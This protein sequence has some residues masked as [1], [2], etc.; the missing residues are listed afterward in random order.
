MADRKGDEFPE[1]R[2]HDASSTRDRNGSDMPD[3]S[4]TD[5]KQP[6]ASATSERTEGD[7]D[8]GPERLDGELRSARMAARLAVREVAALS[9]FEPVSI[10]SVERSENGWRIG[11]EVVESHRIPDSA[12]ILATFEVGLDAQGQLV[13]M[14]RTERYLRGRTQ[15]C[16]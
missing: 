14:R 13:S 5:A 6:S 11:V 15:D 7:P 2:R 4:E 10:V 8:A 9:G 3:E 12:D 1:K 16:R